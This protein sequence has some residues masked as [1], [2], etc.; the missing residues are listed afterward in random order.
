MK[1]SSA[2]KEEVKSEEVAPSTVTVDS[3][4][5]SKISKLEENDRLA[6]ELS[7]ANRRA[8]MA[9]AEKA[10]AQSETADLSYKYVVLQLYMKY[11]L[12]AADAISEGGDII[13]NGAL[14]Q[15]NNGQ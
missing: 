13:Y 6:L 14:P 3:S 8:A 7:K 5:P 11:S 15:T 4:P 2:S 10:V 12:T 9:Q 1:K